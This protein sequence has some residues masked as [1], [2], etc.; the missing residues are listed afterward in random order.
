[1]L[2]WSLMF[3]FVVLSAGLLAIAFTAAGARKILSVPYRHTLWDWA[4]YIP[5]WVRRWRVR[6]LAA[7]RRIRRIRLG[8]Q[9][10]KRVW[11]RLD[12]KGRIFNCTES[13]KSTAAFGA[14]HGWRRS[15]STTGVKIFLS[16]RTILDSNLFQ[17][18][19]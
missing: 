5:P 14:L 9:H 11:W 6:A 1:M 8:G 19:R 10:W 16:R 18:D 12:R 2:Y 7:T 15:V 4:T 17:P 3:L 13:F